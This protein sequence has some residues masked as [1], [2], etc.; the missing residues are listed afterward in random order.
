MKCE[1]FNLTGKG[2]G[3][4]AQAYFNADITDCFDFCD[5]EKLDHKLPDQLALIE[6]F[7]HHASEREHQ[8]D[9]YLINEFDLEFVRQEVD[10]EQYE[11]F[12][13]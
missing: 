5:Q 6:E 1:E 9:G 10:L 12:S 11:L 4:L 8:K 7:E 3:H 2:G 13:G